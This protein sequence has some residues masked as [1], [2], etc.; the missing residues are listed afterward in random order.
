MGSYISVQRSNLTSQTHQQIAQLTDAI[1][2]KVPAIK[3]CIPLS[4]KADALLWTDPLPS[5]SCGVL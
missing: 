4:S 2:N 5:E 3:H 1:N